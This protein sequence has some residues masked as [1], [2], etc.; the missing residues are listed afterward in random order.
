[1]SN[2][3]P[4]STGAE[5]VAD[6]EQRDVE[7]HARVVDVVE[8]RQER[9]EAERHG[10]VN[11]RLAD[12]QRDAERRAPR[13]LRERRRCDLAERDRPA[14]ADGD[15]FARL[16]VELLAGLGTYLVLDLADDPLGLLVMPVDEQ[17]ARR[18]RH[19]P[20]N[21]QD[22]QRMVI[23]GLGTVWILD[24]L[25]VTIVGSIAARLTEKDSGTAT[26]AAGQAA[27]G[28]GSRRCPAQ[29]RS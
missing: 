17:P 14:L 27:P 18:L 25:E 3:R 23:V 4:S 26:T 16:L 2:S 9:A 15:R 21:E 24:G 7:R 13:V 20:A 22:P 28:R 6:R 19:V 11:E 12:E 29:C 8:R 5:E 1:V 10:V